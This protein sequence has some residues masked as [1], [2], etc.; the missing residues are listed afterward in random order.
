MGLANYFRRYIPNF[1]KITFP[2]TELT[3]G[4]FKTKRDSIK[5]GKNH[6]NACKELK[7]KL[8]VPPVLMHYNEDADT[9]LVTDAS[10]FG[11][12]V[13]LQQRDDDGNIHPVSFGAKKL[14]PAQKNYLALELE[15]SALFFGC[16]HFRQYL[17]GNKFTVWSDLK[18]L[19]GLQKLKSDSHVLNRIRTKLIGY[20][21]NVIYKQVIFNKASDFISRHPTDFDESAQIK[22][23]TES[24]LNMVNV[25]S[26]EK[27]YNSVS[28]DD[29]TLNNDKGILF[30]FDIKQ[31][32][33]DL[34][35]DYFDETFHL[36]HCVS[37]DFEM[38]YGIS[39]KF[40]NTYAHVDELKAHNKKIGQIVDLHFNS[41]F[42]I[43]LITKSIFYEK[44][45]YKSL[46]T[47]LKLLKIFCS[48][49]NIKK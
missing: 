12:G 31:I 43:Y 7:N 1:S 34:F 47:T 30:N 42:I 5:W 20:E 15:A 24:D 21:F 10:L 16:T 11:L 36:V 49:Y 33:Q 37:Q 39:L 27:L 19:V 35:S 45:S 6:E 41:Q 17:Y 38:N 18:N 22:Y 2:L 48:T 32:N 44:T 26:T 4:N 25:N 8:I 23:D 46:F 28:Y 9:I 3:K 40:K 29:F 14:L 13:I